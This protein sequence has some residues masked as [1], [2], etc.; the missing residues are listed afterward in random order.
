MRTITTLASLGALLILGGPAASNV[1][2]GDQI[3]APDA[4]KAKRFS[5]T[6]QRL[7]MVTGKTN[8]TKVKVL[9]AKGWKWNKQYPAKLKFSSVPGFVKLNKNLFSQKKGD[10]KSSKTNASVAIKVTGTATGTKKLKATMNFSVCN[11]TTCVIERAAVHV[12]V[13]VLAPSPGNN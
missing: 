5:I 13:E 8:T 3:S 9:V 2:S 6:A 7:K 10:F 1:T 11:A 12:W 4:A